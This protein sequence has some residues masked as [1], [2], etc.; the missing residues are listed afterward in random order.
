MKFLRDNGFDK[1]IEDFGIKNQ[2]MYFGHY[3]KKD[4]DII[5]GI[6]KTTWEEMFEE[7]KKRRGVK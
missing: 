2:S 5:R 3:D 7:A 6:F 4:W 1:I